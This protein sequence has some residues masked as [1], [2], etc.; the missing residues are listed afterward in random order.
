[1]RTVR[2]SSRLL[3]GGVSAQGCVCLARG[4]CLSDTPPWTEWQTPVK[5]L[6]C[7]NYVANGSE[8]VSSLGWLDFHVTCTKN[9]KAEN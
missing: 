5:T 9:F 3:G 2:C 7:R 1:M 6:P 4:L 8:H